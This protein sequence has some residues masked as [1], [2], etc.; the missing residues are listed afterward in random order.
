M[1]IER[2]S[3]GPQDVDIEIPEFTFK[4]NVWTEAFLT[5]MDNIPVDGKHVI[6]MGVGSGVV[7]IDLLKRGVDKYIG[8][9]IDPRIL[10]VA[11]NN[12]QK[13]APEHLQKV[14]L[15]KSDLLDSIPKDICC[16]VICGCLPQV[17][18]PITIELGNN[19]SYA[20][21]FDPEKYQSLLNTYGLGLN[22]AALSQSK[23]RLKPDGSIVL[24]LSGRCGKERLN[25]MYHRH[26]YT[27]R[28]IFEDSIAQLR[29][30]T[31]KTL[32]QA[33]EEG[34]EFFFFKDPKCQERISVK[35]AEDRRINNI[36]SYH[37]IYVI[38]GKIN[39]N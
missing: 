32:V 26:G 37:K 1:N 24:V 10:P 19:D 33:E 28:V 35:E 12:I 38:E 20:R 8:I 17:S 21:Y 23:T 18:K 9:D 36:D 16:D 2:R 22:E 14:E 34:H 4:P 27:T 13:K 15:L 29:E 7:A 11:H 3:L 6:E 31:L 25:Q 39:K 30:T 5:G